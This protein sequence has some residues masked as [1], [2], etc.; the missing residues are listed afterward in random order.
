MMKNN[1][2]T[3]PESVEWRV[4]FRD[5]VLAASL[6]GTVIDTVSGEENDYGESWSEI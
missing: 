6:G 2:Y 4:E 5:A 3:T 1:V